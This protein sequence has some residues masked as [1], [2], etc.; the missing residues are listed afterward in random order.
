MPANV[1]VRE[2]PVDG[3]WSIHPGRLRGDVADRRA[4]SVPADRLGPGTLIIRMQLLVTSHARYGLC[5][6]HDEFSDGEDAPPLSLV[7]GNRL[8]VV[9]ERPKV[10]RADVTWS[11]DTI[12][13]M[14]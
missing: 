10:R 8:T 7:D 14:S 6:V 5:E 2:Q 3:G 11:T 1:G 9:D 13:C 4:A 12:I